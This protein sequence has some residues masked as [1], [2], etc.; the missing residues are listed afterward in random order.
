MAVVRAEGG[1]ARAV[2]HALVGN[3][4]NSVSEPIGGSNVIKAVLRGLGVL[5]LAEGRSNRYLA[6]RH[7]EGVLAVGL[8][9]DVNGIALCVVIVSLSSL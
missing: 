1:L 5:N 6:L 3:I 4:L 9:G 8:L 2:H 7:G